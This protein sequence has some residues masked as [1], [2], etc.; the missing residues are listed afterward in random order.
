MKKGIYQVILLAVCLFCLSGCGKEQKKE[1]METGKQEQL[2]IVTT[3]F[4]PYDFARQIVGEKGTVTMLEPPGGESHSYEPTPQD[5]I[6]IENCD[7]FVYIGGESETWV[8]D[9]L[10]DIDTSKVKVVSCMD[11]V[12]ALEEET[13]EGMEA[14]KEEHEDEE[15]ETEYDEH[16]WTSPENAIAI[17]KQ[18]SECIQQLDQDNQEFYQQR[19]QS[20]LARL[21]QLDQSFQKVVD[22]AER[23]TVIFGDRFPL[24]YFVEEYGLT[25]FAAFPGCAE[26]TEPSAA[27]ITF[28]VDKVK[29][30]NIPV[31]FHIELSNEKIADTICES[32]G[33]EKVLF[34]SCHNIS[35]DDFSAGVTYLELM[36]QNVS[37]LEKALG[38]KERRE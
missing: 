21:E 2:N 27:T 13:V 16:I 19:T 8:E 28:L 35:K 4:A 14:E 26:D 36:E 25:Y 38:T 12:T 23:K 29:E 17:V 31:V 10:K 30:E 7:M 9:L 37:A 18:L 34:H 22:N 3:I 33:A 11:F 24:R 15:G 20:Y 32:T 5:I 1:T 6:S